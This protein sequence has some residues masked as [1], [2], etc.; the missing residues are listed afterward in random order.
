MEV[1]SDKL[2]EISQ[3]H[4]L[5]IWGNGLFTIQVPKVIHELTQADGNLTATGQLTQSGKEIIQEKLHLKIMASQIFALLSNDAQK[6]I[7]RQS[8]EYTWKDPNGV[9][10]EMDGMTIAAI[11]LWHLCPH[12]KVDMYSEIGAVKGMMIAQFDNDI[13]LFFD[14]IK[15]SKLQIDSNDWLAYTDDAFVC[16]IFAQLKN[17]ML[18]HNFKTESTSLERQWQM[19]KE[20][21]SSQLLMDDA[22]TYYTNLVA[23]G[24]WKTQVSKH[25]Q[26]IAFTTQILELKKEV[27]QLNAL[28]TSITPAPAINTS[29]P[30][31]KFE[32]WRL[33]KVNNNEEFNKIKRD[34][35]TFYWCNKHKYPTSETS[36]IYV[37][38]K[39]TEHDAWQAR[40]MA[41]DNRRGRNGHD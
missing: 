18:P 10:E 38:Y 17:E 40:K 25:A 6:V 37:F 2:L 9:D 21:V 12:H 13:D 19:D 3:K 34:G 11:V 23:S 22:S 8:D 33:F 16:D 29:G 35:K 41:L 24:Y 1:Y 36:G 26:I 15:S 27:S 31:G 14:A 39:P 4:A 30:F 20:N 32:Q 5:M 28:A 7:E